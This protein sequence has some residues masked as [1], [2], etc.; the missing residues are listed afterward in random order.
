MH[1]LT[2]L[3]CNITFVKISIHCG[4]DTMYKSI[5]DLQSFLNLTLPLNPGFLPAPDFLLINCFRNCLDNV[6][7]S[8]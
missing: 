3:I 8:Q 1:H 5:S 7:V 6:T 4:N 2:N